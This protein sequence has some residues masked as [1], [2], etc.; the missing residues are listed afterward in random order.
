LDT[1]AC[2]AATTF[3]VLLSAV[4]MMKGNAFSLASWRTSWSNSSPVMGAM[5]QSLMTSPKLPARNFA[6]ASL[7]SDASSTLLK[8]ICLSRLRMMRSIVL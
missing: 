2:L 5:F 7:P 3:S 1:P 6:S 4:I 8:S